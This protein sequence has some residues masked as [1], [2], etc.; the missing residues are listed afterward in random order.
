MPETRSGKK[1]GKKSSSTKQLTLETTGGKKYT[2]N[3]NTLGERDSA[4]T[5]NRQEEII[6][7]NMASKDQET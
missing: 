5:S 1:G 2:V 3:T 4:T 6:E 7:I